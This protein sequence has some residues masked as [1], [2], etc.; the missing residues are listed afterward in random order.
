MINSILCFLSSADSGI[1]F[2]TLSPSSSNGDNDEEYLPENDS[3]RHQVIFLKTLAEIFYKPLNIL[4]A[5][6]LLSLSIILV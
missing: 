3:S 5:L 2:E 1:L 6:V 4:C